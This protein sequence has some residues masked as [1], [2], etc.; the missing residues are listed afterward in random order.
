MPTP[1]DKEEVLKQ[2]HAAIS[3]LA[4]ETAVYW[5]ELYKHCR[6]QG[7]NKKDARAMLMAMITSKSRVWG[8]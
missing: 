4:Q 6:K 1:K 7:F 3:Q 2:R 8:K 5:R